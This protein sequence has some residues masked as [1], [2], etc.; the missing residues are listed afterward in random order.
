MKASTTLTK[1]EHARWAAWCRE[2]NTTLADALRAG[3]R[4]LSNLPTSEAWLYLNKEAYE[5]VQRGLAD[6][7]AGRFAPAPDLTADLAKYGDA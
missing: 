2:Q 5:S 7:K 1:D 6:A 4:L 3:L